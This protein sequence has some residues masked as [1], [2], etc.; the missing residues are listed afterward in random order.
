MGADDTDAPAIAPPL[1][2]VDR[3]EWD[4]L[5]RRGRAD[6]ELH[7]EQITHVL[8][9]VELTEDVI[10]AVNETLTNAGIAVDETV[11][12]HHDE[13][14]PRGSRCGNKRWISRKR[15][16][17]S[18]AVCSIVAPRSPSTDAAAATLPCRS[19]S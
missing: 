12:E 9:H 2:G 6:G 19:A 3:T 5:V 1:E 7:A 10:H 13:T 18:C 16:R 4:D 11:E 8:R 14:P 15:T 17:H